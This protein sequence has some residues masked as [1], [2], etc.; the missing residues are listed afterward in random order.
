VS[1]YHLDKRRVGARIT[2]TNGN[3]VRGDL[4]LA[5]TTPSGAGPELVGDMLNAERG[6]F[7]LGIADSSGG[8]TRTALYN[9]AHVLVVRLVEEELELSFDASYAIAPRR[10]VALSL[11]NGERLFGVLHVVMPDGRTRV[12]D[13]ARTEDRF[14]YL[15]TSDG[16]CVVNFDHVVE[17]A[18]DYE[19]EDESKEEA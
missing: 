3:V 5:H 10:S 8:P 16:T 18:P 7:P 11:E 12:S 9:R 17:I 1:A 6:F 2:L 19:D 4:Y 14:R 13:Y 15:E